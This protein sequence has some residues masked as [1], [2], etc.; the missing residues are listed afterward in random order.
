MD[1]SLE[2]FVGSERWRPV[3]VNYQARQLALDVPVEDAW[4]GRLKGT[5]GLQDLLDA[6]PDIDGDELTERALTRLRKIDV[7]GVADDLDAVAARV[8]EVWGKPPPPP[9]P[10]SN[11]SLLGVRDGDVTEEVRAAIVEGTAADAA[12]YRE[13]GTRPRFK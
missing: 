12:I 9:L 10:R 1:L 8:A 5:G 3:W 7:V 4:K 2:E 6:A 13:A 11:E